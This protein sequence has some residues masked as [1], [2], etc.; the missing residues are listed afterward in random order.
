MYYIFK[1]TNSSCLP[2]TTSN[3]VIYS[4]TLFYNRRSLLKVVAPVKRTTKQLLNMGLTVLFL[5]HQEVNVLTRAGSRSGGPSDV[6]RNRVRMLFVMF[7]NI[8]VTSAP[9]V[10]AHSTSQASDV[11]HT[12]CDN[13]QFVKQFQ[14][15]PS[16]EIKYR[17][18]PVIRDPKSRLLPLD[19]PLITP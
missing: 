14:N 15:L 9:F 13:Q 12:N 11:I 4:N 3:Y 8:L 17:T 1:V 7:C 10:L 19:Q 5:G 6:Y 18:I 2:E 16:L